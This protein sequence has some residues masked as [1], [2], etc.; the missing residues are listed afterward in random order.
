LIGFAQKYIFVYLEQT[1][2]KKMTT[3]L[4]SLFS[5][6]PI[7]KQLSFSLFSPLLSFTLPVASGKMDKLKQ[8][9]DSDNKPNKM[10]R[11][12]NCKK[13]DRGRKKMTT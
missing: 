2:D 5:F 1:D 12:S 10:K 9:T 8:R 3:T 7:Q 6:A 11:T 4:P 13:K